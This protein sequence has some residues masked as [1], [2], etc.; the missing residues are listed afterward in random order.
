MT[1]SITKT[2]L[3]VN[4]YAVITY[5]KSIALYLF[6]NKGLFNDLVARYNSCYLAF[7]KTTLLLSLL[8]A[9]SAFAQEKRPSIVI[10]ETADSS[11]V[12]ATVNVSTKKQIAVS[13][14]GHSLVFLDENGKKVQAL[15]ELDEDGMSKNVLV[16][17]LPGDLLAITMRENFL[18]VDYTG[19]ILS[20]KQLTRGKAIYIAPI[21]IDSTHVLVISN[22]GSP[23]SGRG[24]LYAN[25][26]EIKGS[27]IVGQK[28]NEMGELSVSY[29][30]PSITKDGKLLLTSNENIWSYE[31]KTRKFKLFF[32]HP[33]GKTFGAL[34]VSTTGTVV[35]ASLED[36]IC[37]IDAQ[38]SMCKTT[39]ISWSAGLG[40]IATSDGGVIVNLETKIRKY[41]PNGADVWTVDTAPNMMNA[42]TMIG[43]KLVGTVYSFNLREQPELRYNAIVLGS[44]GK[45]LSRVAMGFGGIIPAAVAYDDST[46]VL[47]DNA[48][49]L[50]FVAY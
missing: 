42:I 40:A 20:R 9:V 39:G 2:A 24:Y 31:L 17:A 34:T 45:E 29:Q 22:W 36:D 48:G 27:A 16:T 28:S 38:S 35:A 32:K 10:H 47:G 12:I 41:M 5:K 26:F 15:N 1:R 21:I 43:T 25:M 7:M 18:I 14:G 49:L 30:T 46:M 6:E 13:T 37:F 4:Q 19:K 44:D 3:S 23:F 50:H 8:L 33:E 11:H